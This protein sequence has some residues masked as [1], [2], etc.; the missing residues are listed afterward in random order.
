M[1]QEFSS[2][3]VTTD[4]LRASQVGASSKEP[5]CQCRRHKRHGFDPWIGKIPWRRAWQLTPVCLPGESYGQRRLAGYGPRV[6]KSQ[7]RLK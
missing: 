7:T 4:I 5:A 2:I 3:G 1:S 6:T